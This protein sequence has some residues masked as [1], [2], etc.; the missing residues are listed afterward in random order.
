MGDEEIRD[1][2]TGGVGFGAPNG[3]VQSVIV[4]FCT[5]GEKEFEV[6]EG[7]VTGGHAER[8][9][10]VSIGYIW[11]GPVSEKIVKQDVVAEGGCGAC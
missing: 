6:G 4:R 1:G 10:V 5:M 11:I 8:G 7:A 2:Q 3:H 9:L